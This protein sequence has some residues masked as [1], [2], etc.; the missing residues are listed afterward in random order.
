MVVENAALRQGKTIG[1]VIRQ[2]IININGYDSGARL[3]DFDDYMGPAF[4]NDSVANRERQKAVDARNDALYDYWQNNYVNPDKSVNPQGLTQKQIDDMPDWYRDIS[5][6]PDPN[7]FAGAF[8]DTQVGQAVNDFMNDP[9][10]G[11][12][13]QAALDAGI[14]VAGGVA[15][16]RK[17]TRWI[18]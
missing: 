3:A 18:G 2:G 17:S 16:Q 1:E 14:G 12:W 9:T 11:W 7:N 8:K 10:H 5:T 4:G 13:R 6:P 15:N